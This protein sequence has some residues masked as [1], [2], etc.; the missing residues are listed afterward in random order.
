MHMRELF[1]WRAIPD[2]TSESYALPT[3]N[4]TMSLMSSV[5]EG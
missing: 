1:F 3:S 5:G 2:M 4:T